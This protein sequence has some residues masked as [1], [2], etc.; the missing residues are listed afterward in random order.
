MMT[1]RLTKDSAEVRRVTIDFSQ[2][3][4][5]NE[6]LSAITGPVVAIEQMQVWQQ[7]QWVTIPPG[8]I[9]DATPL[10]VASAV[11][12][13]SGTQARLMLTSG[14]PGITYK[15]TFV[16]TAGTS[17]RQKQVDLIVTVRTPV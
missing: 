16:A 17:G 15:V 9:V 12:L 14:T 6:A 10:S 4:D 11:I 8:G 3:L 1:G 5:S 13:G 7:G 2:W